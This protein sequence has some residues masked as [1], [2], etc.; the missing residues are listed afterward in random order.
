MTPALRPALALLLIAL[1]WSLSWAGPPPDASTERR[2]AHLVRTDS[3]QMVTLYAARILIDSVTPEGIRVWVSDKEFEWVRSRGW[4]IRFISPTA[5]DYWP[6]EETKAE[7]GLTYPLTT[8]PT[9]DEITAALEDFASTY[10][11]LCRLVSIGKSVQNRDLWFLKITDNPDL[12]EDE[13]E[14]KYISTMHGNETL[15]VI[16]CLNLIH[17]LLAGHGTDPRLTSLVDETEIWIM[18]LMNPDGYSRSP[19]SRFNSQGIDLNRNFPDRV[20]DDANDPTGRAPEVRAVMNFCAVH[21][22]VLSANFHTGALVVNYPYDNSEFAHIQNHPDWYTPD[23]DVFVDASLA[24]SSNN[25]PMYASPYFTNGITNGIAWYTLVGGMQD[26]NY[27]WMGCNEVTI[28]V[29]DIF[30]PS[31]SALG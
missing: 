26:W 5:E 17:D 23:N 30:S 10:P 7:K 4:D 18:P 28:E 1:G 19:R 31:T 3:K 14:F 15:G 21:S 16:L 13:P 8:Y 12:E 27:V 2:A 11:S 6:E 20:E 9:F 22:F 25:P 24:Y 29:S